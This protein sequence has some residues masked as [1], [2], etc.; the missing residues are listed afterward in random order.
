[1]IEVRGG[2][3]WRG[4][5][6]GLPA[7][8]IE[9]SALVDL[10]GLPVGSTLRVGDVSEV[11]GATGAA[12]VVMRDH[13]ELRGHCGLLPLH[14]DDLLVG[15]IDVVPD[16]LSSPEYSILRTE[17]ERTWVGLVFS[18]S[19]ATA[20]SA[21]PVSAQD[22]WEPIRHHARSICENPREL[23]SASVGVRRLEM[24]R[25]GNEVTPLLVRAAARGRP[26]P[27]PVIESTSD[28]PENT[29]VGD[30]LMRLATYARRN[31]EPEVQIEVERLLRSAPFGWRMTA[32]T[33]VPASCR[34]DVRY[35]HVIGIRQQLRSPEAQPTEGP[36]E[37]RLGVRGLSRLYEYWVFL[38][39]LEAARH[40]YGEPLGE[41]WSA[42][43]KD[44]GDG[45][46]H[47][48]LAAGTTVE[49]P[50][51]VAVAFEPAIH[52]SGL[53]WNGLELVPHPDPGR[54]MA[55]VTPDV[56][57][58]RRGRRPWMLVVDAK[59]VAR[60]FV[61]RS[62]AEV[63][64]KYARFRLDGVPVGGLV[65]VAHPHRG[66]QE[67]W[68]GYGYMPLLPGDVAPA[69]PL[70][71]PEPRTPQ[72]VDRPTPAA[73]QLR[74]S[75]VASSTTHLSGSG[76]VVVAD[77]GW[78][79]R[80]LGP[81]RIR[82]EDLAR[83]AGGPDADSFHLVQPDLVALAPFAAAVRRAGWE[84]H[85]T[86]SVLRADLELGIES[87]VNAAA[88]QPRPVVVISDDASL[89]ERLEPS[90]VGGRQRPDLSWFADLAAVDDV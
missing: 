32:L 41:G 5:G 84:V 40:R 49:F 23:L 35:R 11:V 79:Y 65:L 72:P 59:Y 17:L 10:R 67:M 78:M 60:S 37:L 9:E 66:L 22:L 19:G 58:L 44:V 36:G 31:Q 4:L 54:F 81:R 51:G 52:T 55:T 46:L 29:I 87:V 61:H 43:A 7:P 75:S 33:R 90:S 47:L 77:Q 13:P 63:H 57:V 42:L 70:P 14:V 80:V 48:E 8:R 83:K 3:G 88:E 74:S 45:R 69:M 62:A 39:V 73:D 26:A 85:A 34:H 30:T 56:V 68:A 20:V 12:R 76:T 50:G 71:P 6:P 15:E 27:V 28:L 1:M 18:A 21:R 86:A 82:F 89:R 2:R 25:R 53:G 38:K 16:K 24:L 64:E